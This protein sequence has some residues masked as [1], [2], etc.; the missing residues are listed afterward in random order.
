[1]V[2][3]TLTLMD[4]NGRRVALK[5]FLFSL[6]FLTTI[7]VYS[8][9]IPQKPTRQSALAA[10]E[11]NDNELALRQFSELSATYPKDPLYKYYCGACL[12]KLEREPAR[13]AILLNDAINGSAAI[14]TVPADCI[15][16]L[17]R[18]QQMS[19]NFSEAILSYDKFISQA[20][21]KMAKEKN[22][23]D[24]IKQC[25]EKK[26]I[27]EEPVLVSGV[28][29][30]NEPVEKIAVEKQNDS[31]ND[32][33]SD[34]LE[35]PSSGYDSLLSR[36]LAF[37]VSSD[38]LSGLA[39]KLRT[40][41]AVEDGP[42]RNDLKIQSQNFDKLALDKRRKADAI[43]AEAG[44]L[45]KGVILSDTVR[46][47]PLVKAEPEV[48]DTLIQ[49]RPV[50]LTTTGVAAQGKSVFSEFEILEKPVWKPDE[51]VV[52]NPEVP[53]GLVYRIQVAVFRNPVSPSY[54]K[55]I[56]P[57]HG[58]RNETS[59]ITSYYA[60]MFRRLADASKALAKVRGL[61][62]KD[63]FV[64]SLMDK[65]TISS[66][67]AALLEKEW[68][69]KPLYTIKPAETDTVPQTLV[70]RI[71]VKRS[72]KPL[73]ADQVENMKKMAGTRGFDIIVTEKKQSVYLAGKFLTFKSASEFADLLVRNG[74]RDSKVVAYLG[75]REI[76]VETAKQ[77]F[78]EH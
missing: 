73:P 49:A 31:L 64:A 21:K 43:M 29:A 65:K 24:F 59:G 37:Q 23:P 13:A 54:F 77:L 58:F 22:V 1:M 74:Y 47:E 20:G 6:W 18:A 71:E 44:K 63:S 14:R 60:G 39:E 70:F 52:V 41:L 36:A 15:F 61:G 42:A 56:K 4:F 19:G 10:F 5:L 26:G 38:S 11:R 12:V 55:G 69:T 76:P 72:P 9:Y 68:G 78:D 40:R 7:P 16:W 75:E 33:L 53:P 8:M 30:A 48:K 17:G 27:V 51:K 28:I 50:T 67:R 62:F 2:V 34:P 3:K 35:N 32:S 45:N 46:A 57:V 25:Q 66:D